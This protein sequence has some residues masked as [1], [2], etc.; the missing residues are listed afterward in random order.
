[1]DELGLHD[2][3]KK[4]PSTYRQYTKTIHRCYNV[5]YEVYEL[6]HLVPYV[7]YTRQKKYIN[8]LVTLRIKHKNKVIIFLLRQ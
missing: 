6:M 8:T 3:P 7:V 4:Q 1:M 5:T 2:I